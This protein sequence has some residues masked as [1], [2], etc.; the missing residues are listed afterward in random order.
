MTP[1]EFKAK[2]IEFRKY[3]KLGIIV[4][5]L[6]QPPNIEPI[7]LIGI[8]PE[9][10]IFMV[11]DEVALNAFLMMELMFYFD[12]PNFEFSF[13][14]QD[15]ANEIDEEQQKRIKVYQDALKVH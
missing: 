12:D 4:R 1:C 15:N 13:M 6:R 2:I 3:E 11:G 5:D 10:T 14:H 7:S 8:N 9:D